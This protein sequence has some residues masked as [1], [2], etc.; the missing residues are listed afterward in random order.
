VRSG[1]YDTTPLGA[2]GLPRRARLLVTFR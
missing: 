2:S 1:R